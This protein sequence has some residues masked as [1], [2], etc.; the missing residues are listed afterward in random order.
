[1]GCQ[2]PLPKSYAKVAAVA[3]AFSSLLSLA[4]DAGKQSSRISDSRL[5]FPNT[6][7]G[8]QVVL[9][10]L[11]LPAVGIYKASGSLSDT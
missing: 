10:W 9:K 11:P 7:G 2:D 4:D 1:M 5:Y 3:Y 6:D 8:L